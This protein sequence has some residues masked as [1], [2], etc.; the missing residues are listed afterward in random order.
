[1]NREIIEKFG[2]R[3][4]IRVCGICWKDNKIAYGKS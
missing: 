3:V 1:M 4:R 2:N